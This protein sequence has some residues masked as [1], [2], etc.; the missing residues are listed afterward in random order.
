MFDPRTEPPISLTDA[1]RLPWLKSRQSGKRVDVRT[2][3]RWVSRGKNGVRLETCKMGGG[4]F[5]SEA[6]IIRF[7]ERAENPSEAGPTV[8]ANRIARG[9]AIANAQARLAAAGI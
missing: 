6:A 8:N 3:H 4:R 7:L 5:T 2:L 9:N 1:T